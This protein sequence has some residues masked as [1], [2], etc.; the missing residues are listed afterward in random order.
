MSKRP[1]KTPKNASQLKKGYVQ[2]KTFF[3]TNPRLLFLKEPYRGRI[4][5][6]G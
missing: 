1:K 2:D 6:Q 5:L 3:I 4:S